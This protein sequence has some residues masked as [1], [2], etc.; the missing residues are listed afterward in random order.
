MSD[1]L[2]Q[3]DVLLIAADRDERRLL[4]GELLEAGYDV[5][6]IPEFER[7]LGE[8]LQHLIEPRLILIDVGDD[9]KLTPQAVDYLLKAAGIVPVILLVG[10]F[11]RARWESL[12]PRLDALLCRPIAI[13]AIVEAVKGVLPISEP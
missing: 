1:K 10:T 3:R 11:N 8:L 12:G 6:P 7:A 4:F 5:V 13:V 9:E 2:S